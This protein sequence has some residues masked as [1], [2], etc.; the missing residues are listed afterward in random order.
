MARMSVKVRGMAELKD[1]LTPDLY[2]HAAAYVVE[3][4]GGDLL[5]VARE[6]VATTRTGRLQRSLAL[7]HGQQG[8]G[9]WFASVDM[10]RGNRQAAYGWVLNAGRRRNRGGKASRLRWRTTRRTTKAFFSGSLR[11]IRAT[12]PAR[13]AEA[14]RMVQRRWLW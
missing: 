14:A 2:R 10:A 12:F 13:I 4:S 6:R 5:K 7:D 3:K 9:K 1:R 11:P 8:D